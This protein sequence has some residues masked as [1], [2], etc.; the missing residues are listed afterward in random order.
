MKLEHYERLTKQ[1]C[2]LI[3]T[4]TDFIANLS[5]ISALLF[6]ELDQLNWAGFYLAQGREL[7]LGPFQGNPACTRIPFGKGVCGT[8]IETNSVQRV[9]DVHKFEGHIA[10][11]A[12]SNSEIVIPFT[13]AGK[14]VGVLD[15]DSPE[16][17]RFSEID[18]QGLTKLMM[19]VEKLLNS[20]SN[21]D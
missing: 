3:E 7:V 4:E 10:C 9:H 13:V 20:H 5:N 2:A 8:A 19:S 15:I 17:G 1:A 11:D 6:M 18:E 21:V 12:A 14:L 16:V